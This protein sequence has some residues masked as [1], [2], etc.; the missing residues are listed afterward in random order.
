MRI[1]GMGHALFATTL[2]VVGGLGLATG[3]YAA[4]WQPVL[5]NVP[6]REVLAY[7]CAVVSLAC[8]A[9]LFWPRTAA[10]AARTLLVWLAAWFLL[11]KAPILCI[12]PGSAVSWENCAE[13]AVIVAGTWV[14]YARFCGDRDRRPSMLV[15]DE[16]N[17]RFALALYALALVAFGVSHFAY[18]PQT[19]AL[20]P[21]WLPAHVALAYLTGGTYIAAGAAVLVGVCARLATVLAT[22]QMGLFTLLVWVPVVMAS[23]T[24]AQWSEFIVSWAITVASWAIADSWPRRRAAPSRRIGRAERAL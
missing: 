15:A 7:S 1:A 17:S 3:G 23:P 6:A 19:A 24:R 12:A 4:L 10:T 14:L 22:V 8:G 18:A 5:Q 2:I 20:V 13:T 21:A 11:F 9:G 16:R